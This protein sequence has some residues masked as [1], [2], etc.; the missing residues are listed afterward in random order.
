MGHSYTVKLR[1]F[2]VHRS[3]LSLKEFF[4]VYILRGTASCI[5]MHAPHNS[6]EYSIVLN[7]IA[8]LVYPVY[9]SVHHLHS[10]PQLSLF[11]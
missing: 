10:H 2:L 4:L 7:K 8:A 1:V 5:I 11:Q 9:S 6:N 3:A